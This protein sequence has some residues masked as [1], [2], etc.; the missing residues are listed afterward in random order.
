MDH[1]RYIEKHL[2]KASYKKNGVYNNT[3]ILSRGK[4]L[5]TRVVGGNYEEQCVNYLKQHG[6]QIAAQNYKCKIGEIDIIAVK[7]NILRFIE[8]KYRKNEFFGFPIEAVNKRKQNKIMKTALWFLGENKEYEN[9][10]CSF[11]VISITENDVEYLF[12][13][14]GAM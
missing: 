4:I 11:D 9:M 12:N 3:Q 7:N 1:V 13:C 5:N 6:F 14:F 8:V 2:L 10:Q